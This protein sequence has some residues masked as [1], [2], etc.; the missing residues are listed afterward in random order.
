MRDWMTRR[1]V[2]HR[3]APATRSAVAWVILCSFF[4]ISTALANPDPDEQPA[5]PPEPAAEV[6]KGT[7][8]VTGTG[9]EPAT[10]SVDGREV[11]PLPWT[12]ELQAG[13]HDIVA[14]S[15]HGISA[16]RK[17]AVSNNGRTE[18][19]LNV[20]ENPAKLRV[21]TGLPGAV[22]RVDGVPYAN[23]K[24]DG[25]VAAGKHVVSVEHEG[26]TPSVIRVTLDPDE[27]KTV[28]NVVL[29]KAPLS[30]SKA[31]VGDR[32]IYTSVALVGMLGKATNSFN[33]ACPADTLG[34]SC[35]SWV[36]LGGELDV[37]VGY[38]F[39]TFGVEGFVLGGTN[40][41]SADQRFAQDVTAAQ[42][43]YFGIARK[44]SYLIFEPIVGGG[45]AGR[46]STKGKSYRLSTALGFGAAWR[47]A[48]VHRKV[49]ATEMTPTGGIVR[50]DNTSMTPSGADRAVAL[51]IWD[52]DVQLG[53]TPGTRIFLGIRGQVE[54]GSEP[55]MDL[56][57]GNLGFS[58]ATGDHL[59]LGGG[60]MTV[61]R[62][63]A[64]FVGPR[65]GVITGF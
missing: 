27:Q 44:E 31:P 40:L 12:G 17:V 13:T 45:A 14:H 57:S 29:E 52:S 41:T 42:S 43:P 24:F 6:G 11:G 47:S 46:V 23:G 3:I 15:A 62:N 26:Y 56:G 2:T 30:L 1:C 25:E 8:I 36:N 63:P 54:L 64:F 55:T 20:V 10:L 28:E 4:G 19:E 22:I 51:L 59:P 53:D 49:D 38:S 58:E 65:L 48:I 37:H 34:G 60:A 16:T 21:T 35:S 7:L 39:G 33:M 61:R 9:A 32:G 50:R 5:P 18:L